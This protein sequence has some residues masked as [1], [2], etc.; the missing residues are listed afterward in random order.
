M[1]NQIITNQIEEVRLSNL[2]QF[3]SL[4]KRLKLN[5]LKDRRNHR[6]SNHSDRE[7]LIFYYNRLERLDTTIKVFSSRAFENYVC[8][9]YV[10]C[11]NPS[12]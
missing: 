7:K 12:H 9:S 11:I 2:L 4:V 1:E 3:L 5:S 10:E 6:I 8:F